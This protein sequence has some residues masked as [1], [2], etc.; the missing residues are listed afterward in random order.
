MMIGGQLAR[1][2]AE[3]GA[4]RFTIKGAVALEMRLPALGRATRDI[5]LIA[6][7][8]ASEP[9]IDL[10]RQALSEAYQ[11]FSFRVKG[12]P[13]VMP[14]ESMRA[15][16]VLEYLGSGWATVRVDVS[17]REGDATEIELVAP[18]DLRPLGLVTPEPLPCLSLRYHLAQKIHAM[19]VPSEDRPNERFRDLADVLL[20]RPLLDDVTTLGRAC[21]LVFA[22][23]DT[24][25]WPPSFD[26]PPAWERPFE[27][28]AAELGLIPSAF[29]A[30]VEEGR[31][32]I[33]EAARTVR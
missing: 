5:D 26:P 21:Q 29:T 20:L 1:A 18:I 7:A 30:A 33:A 8:T 11:G 23:R 2:A 28:L 13:Y 32:F 31:A 10:L 14:N 22:L 19:T 3:G 15:E 25:P 24:H 9:L 4:S 16:V 6:D 17:P 27:A 12:D